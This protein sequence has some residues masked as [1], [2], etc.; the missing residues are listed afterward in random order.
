[1]VFGEE[2]HPVLHLVPLDQED[3]GSAAVL[4]R[5]PKQRVL[6]EVEGCCYYSYSELVD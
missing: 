6:V 3:G 5:L 4:L 1:M 2:D